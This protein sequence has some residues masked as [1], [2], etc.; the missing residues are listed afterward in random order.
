M[1]RAAKIVGL[2]AV[3]FAG[4]DKEPAA[5]AETAVVRQARPQDVIAHAMATDAV[6]RGISNAV[7]QAY[8]RSDLVA[9]RTPTEPPDTITHS[10]KVVTVVAAS[11]QH[12]EVDDCGCKAN[13]LGG[14][15]RR[16]MLVDDVGTEN[17]WAK[18]SWSAQAVIPVDAGDLLFKG[19]T[20]DRSG[21]DEQD[22]SRYEAQTLIEALSLQPPKAILAGELDFALGPDVFSQLNQGKALPWISANLRKDGTALLPGHVVVEAAGQNV[23]IVGLSKAE[24]ARKGYWEE[25]GMAV[26]PPLEAYRRER[27]LAASADWVLMLSNLG[28]RD[29]EALVRQMEPAERPALV[30]VS[31]SNSLTRE[32][33]WVDG[34]PLV[35]PHSQGKMVA[36]VD[37]LLNGDGAPTWRN[38][39]ADLRTLTQGYRRAWSTYAAA[40]QRRSDVVRNR[41][42]NELALSRL[43]PTQ[44]ADK[45]RLEKNQDFLSKELERVETRVRIVSSEL[46]DATRKLNAA[47]LAASTPPQGDD[48]LDLQVAEV[49][50]NI[51]SPKAVQTLIDRRAK[52]RPDAG[53]GA[54]GP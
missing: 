41:A 5:P 8:R 50:L 15:G 18:R 7:G 53:K 42:E 17:I 49:K 6:V 34:V 13:P 28:V 43:E 54:K 45:A 4:C 37:L 24:P 14:I 25:R 1:I 40:R 10:A 19:P 27:K 36:R 38:Q 16:L 32:P 20:L 39:R 9:E 21:E 35:E 23:A 29:T 30:V 51:E 11:N 33:L 12:G 52:K 44:S 3:V 46:M 48:W 47:T 2:M 31:G 22:K 26:D